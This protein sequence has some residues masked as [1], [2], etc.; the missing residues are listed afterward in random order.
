MRRPYDP[1][2]LLQFAS[3]GSLTRCALRYSAV[4]GR[5]QSFLPQLAAANEAL[6]ELPDG[7]SGFE[8]EQVEEA[9]EVLTQDAQAALT[10]ADIVESSTGGGRPADSDAEQDDEAPQIHMDLYCGVLQEKNE[11]DESIASTGVLRLPGGGILAPPSADAVNESSSDDE[12]VITTRSML[13]NSDSDSDTE[14]D[15]EKR[16]MQAAAGEGQ[17][18]KVQEVGPTSR[19]SS[20]IPGLPD[21]TDRTL[22]D[23][24]VPHDAH[25]RDVMQHIEE[26]VRWHRQQTSDGAAG[27]SS[28]KCVEVVDVGGS[29]GVYTL[30][31]VMSVSS[32]GAQPGQQCR[33]TVEVRTR[34]T[35][36]GDLEVT[37]SVTE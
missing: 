34:R 15:D 26:T 5:L 22:V 16:G 27:V 8:L 30:K 25:D 20:L 21:P 31:L 35:A 13:A 3:A 9:E 29:D 36:D 37:P 32:T 19:L 7:G 4:L 2:G 6:G 1:C 23:E 12:V 10:A 33:Q 17:S 28:S 24:C 14:S 18:R 11:Q